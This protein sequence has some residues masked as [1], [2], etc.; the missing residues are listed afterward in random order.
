MS[1]QPTFQAQNP[2]ISHYALGW[3]SCT[4]FAAAMA[5]DFDTL[6]AIRPTG[7]QVR[8]LT[9]DTIGGLNLAQVDRAA[10]EGWGVNLSTVYRLPWADYVKR[11]NAGCAAILQGGY[12]P[13]A[14]SPYD[15]GRG[16][17]GNHAVL[18]TPTRQ[19]LDPLADG[20]A[21]GV[22]QYNAQ[23]YPDAL[24]RDFAGRLDLGN[25]NRLGAGLV[26]A[27]FT[28]DNVHTFHI[29]F[30]GSFFIYTVK[31]GVITGR[32]SHRFGGPTGAPCTAQK[33]YPWPKHASRSLVRITDG[34]LAGEYVGTSSGVVV[35]MVP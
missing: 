5:I 7:G 12:A 13:I 2:A 15:A 28:R 31:N 9:H 8:N 23:P 33:V 22:Y 4:A 14:D 17:R 18:D 10:L 19:V 35:E 26:Y 24:L 3:S 20:R 29:R 16:F 34:K 6:G 27:S 1:Y 11:R 32:T 30:V 25:G 21:A